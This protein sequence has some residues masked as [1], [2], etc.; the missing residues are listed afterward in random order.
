M[1]KFA[2]AAVF[3]FAVVGYALAEEINVSITKVDSDK[4]TI[5]YVKKAGFGGGFG[6]KGGKGKKKQDDQPAPDPVTASY[7][8]TVKVAKGEIKKD[9]GGDFKKMTYTVGDE[10][11]SGVKDDIFTKI[12]EKGVNARITIADDGPDKG[13][14]TQILVLPAFKKKKDAN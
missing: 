4:A 9:E 10:I 14:I 3:T 11:K 12:D 2:F 13:K 8:A 5:T 6:G 7:T 1:K